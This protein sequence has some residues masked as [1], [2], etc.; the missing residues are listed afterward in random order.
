LKYSGNIILFEKLDM[1]FAGDPVLASTM[2][3]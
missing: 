2:K 1:A 3:T